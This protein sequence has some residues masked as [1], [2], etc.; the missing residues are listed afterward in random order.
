MV[1]DCRLRSQLRSEQNCLHIGT[2][3]C[4]FIL[5]VNSGTVKGKYPNKLEAIGLLVDCPTGPIID[6]HY[7]LVFAVSQQ[8]HI[9]ITY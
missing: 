7:A 6:S 1:P 4:Q 5:T 9:E 2:R 8:Y 3:G